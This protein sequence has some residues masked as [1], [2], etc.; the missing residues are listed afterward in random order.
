[1]NRAVAQASLAAGPPGAVRFYS[2]QLDGLRFIAALLLIVHHAPAMPMLGMLKTYGWAGVDM[3]LCLSAF[4]ITRLILLEHERTG[5][6]S[7]RLF[8]IRRVLRIWPLYLSYATAVCLLSFVT[9][10]VSGRT[11]TAWWLSHISFS[12]NI[13]TAIKGYSPVAFSEHLWT[14][15]LEE[16]A[17]IVMPLLLIAFLAQGAGRRR[18]LFV[19]AGILAALLTARAACTLAQVPHPFV[20]VLPLRGDAFVLGALA[21]IWTHGR[22]GISPAPL[23]ALGAVLVASVALFPPVDQAGPYQVFGY[24]VLAL[25]C[26][27]IVVACEHSN[28]ARVVLGLGPLRYFGKIS[29]GIYVYHLVAIYVA[30]KVFQ[31]LGVDNSVLLFLVAVAVAL[32]TAA[33]SYRI[34]E[35]PFLLLK[36]RFTRIQ[37]R[38]A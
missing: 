24:T 12:N 35:R 14:I 26:T 10:I 19:C 5:S 22:A 9:G 18:A 23:F 15:S 25:G 36:E 13:L 30:V 3:F 16:Q 11:A 38:P 34:L 31:R 37:S 27:A 29:Y 33:L 1:M 8:F 21:A 2:P 32:A 4:L 6:F 20:W 28:A 17:Y 7:L